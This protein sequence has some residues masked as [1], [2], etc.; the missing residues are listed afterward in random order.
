M[1]NYRYE[2]I[3]CP[4]NWESRGVK[5]DENKEIEVLKKEI[6]E[7]LKPFE[8][9][10]IILFGSYA[11]GKPN[12]YSDIDLYIVTKDEFIPQS[13]AERRELV[14]KFSNALMDIRL[15]IPMDLIVHTKAMYIR[16]KKLNSYFAR[17][18]LRKGINLL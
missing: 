16:F 10:K 15:R 13:Y 14:R 3:I 11:Y 9:E 1:V 2:N 8:L 6:F 18:I 7:R 12:K 17:E 4:L 5:M